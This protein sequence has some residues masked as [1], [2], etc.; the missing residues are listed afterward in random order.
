MENAKIKNIIILVLLLVNAFFLGMLLRDRALEQQS[1]EETA[2][3]L[4]GILEAMG[5][6]AGEDLD[7]FQEPPEKCTLLRDA[8]AEEEKVS[9]ILGSVTVEDLGG[10]IYYYSSPGGK[11]SLRGTGEID[12]IFS[13][14]AVT[15]GGKPERAAAR[16]MNKAG[17]SVDAD[18]AELTVSGDSS[19][20]TLCCAWDG[21]PIYNA[22]VSLDFVGGRLQ[23]L[24][25][26]RT[27]D[28]V[29]S[30]GSEDVMS[31]VSAVMRFVEIMKSD[32]LICSRLEDV[33]AG[34]IMSVTVS[35]EC[36]LTPVWKAVT[37]TGN[38]YINALTG[39]TETVP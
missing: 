29:S 10:N 37:D 5:V 4:R 18:S 24:T 30:S 25:G 14:G 11:A 35:G 12:M 3:E 27:F 26:V 13:G 22:R 17:F 38:I 20:V 21:C 16:L 7:F 23:M 2:G 36:T 33:E 19:S 6:Y 34:Y 32:G 1:R 15:D 39:K 8:Q 9:A 31:C 28:R